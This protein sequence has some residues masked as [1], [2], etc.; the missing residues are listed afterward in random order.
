MF[1]G[2]AFCFTGGMPDLKRSA[3][4]REVRAR[5]GLTTDVV[6]DRLNYL[7]VGDKP[8]PAWKYG[9]FGRKIELARAISGGAVVRTRIVSESAFMLSLAQT[10]QSNGGAIDGKVVVCSYKFL[11][12]DAPNAFDEGAVER[13]LRGLQDEHRCHVTVREHWAAMTTELYGEEMNLS[14]GRVPM[15]ASACRV[16]TCRV[17]RHQ[18]LEEPVNP[19]VEFVARGFEAIRGVD[20]QLS[21]FERTEGSSSYINLL[22]EVPTSLRVAGL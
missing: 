12:P 13:L 16:V 3:A 5:G 22:R 4:E 7:I 20:G 1:E 17:V 8:S 9:S 14:V 11:V 21:W 15:R 2:M 18:V 10:P 19:F 6:N